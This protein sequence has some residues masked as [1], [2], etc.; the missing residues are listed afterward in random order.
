MDL[1]KK[2]SLTICRMLVTI[3][4]PAGSGKSTTA[5]LLAKELGLTYLDTGAM[6]RAVTWDSLE[7]GIRPEDE[8]GVT[9]RA[10]NLKLEL[11]DLDGVPSLFLDGEPLGNRIRSSE[12]SAAVSPVSKHPGV[13]KSLV[14]V[15]RSL[16]ANGGIVAEGRDTGT[17]VF[18]FADVK[19]FLVADI[20]S[21]ASRRKNQMADMDMEGDI[22]SIR[23]N[24][25]RRDH[26]D[27][28]REHSPLRQPPGS[29]VVD[30]S[31]ISIQEQVELIKNIVISKAQELARLRV[32]PGEKNDKAKMPLYWRLASVSV[33]IFYKMIFGLK[34]YGR[35]NI[36][37]RENYIFA[38]NHISNS[39]PPI[40]GSALK[41]K[42]WILAKR[43]LFR[44]FFLGRLIKKFN[45]IPVSRGKAD[46]L[47][48]MT[49]MDKLLKGDSVLL[50]PEGTRSRNGRIRELKSG[51]GYYAIQT[52]RPIVPLFI[53]GCDNM[54]ECF[55]RKRKLE[56]HIG[57]PIRMDPGYEADDKKSDYQ[58]LASMTREEMGMLKYG[59]EN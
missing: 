23:E 14:K 8:E 22:D 26:I 19:I 5:S 36:S 45:A 10:R 55:L 58:M 46:R 17:T 1:E 34:T 40:V 11:K 24:I 31:G 50:F 57:R 32:W 33:Y 13:R 56:V 49:I 20:E 27:S 54:K 52:G 21:R 3:D 18:P 30:T 42:I 59:A 28:T 16:A 25:N 53:R 7:N 15:Q 39:D 4:G 6:Y 12:V 43:E 38:S 9:E 41:R 44:N 29:I 51:L 2:T 37:Y 35:D 47:S 48:V